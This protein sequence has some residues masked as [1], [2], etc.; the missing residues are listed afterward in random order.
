MQRSRRYLDSSSSSLDL[1]NIL[2]VNRNLLA[3]VILDLFGR[4]QSDVGILP[5]KDLGNFL[6]SRSLCLNVDFVALGMTR[7][8]GVMLD[9]QK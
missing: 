9:L 2:D 5:I 7:R 1:T 6:E 4:G 3:N 8:K